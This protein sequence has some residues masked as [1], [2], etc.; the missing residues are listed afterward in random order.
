[1]DYSLLI[2]IITTLCISFFLRKSNNQKNNKKHPP[3]PGPFDFSV[4][5]SLLW[6]V[7]NIELILRDLK[8]KY[9]PLFNLRIGIISRPSIFVASHS[10]AY[11]ALVQ[12]GAV[13]SDRPKAAQTNVIIHSS[14]IN[15]S[16]A[17]YG[18]LWRL[19]RRN[20]TSS[21]LHPSRTKSFSKAR[22]RALS[23][24][25][26]QL[27]YHS[28]SAKENVI[29]HFQYAT[30]YLLVLMCF[31]DKIDETQVKRIKDVQRRWI[32]SVGRFI[33]LSFLPR[34][35]EKIIFRSRWKELI[36]LQ[37]E[38][39]RIFI[40]LI[41]ARKKAKSSNNLNHHEEEEV[42]AYVDTLLNLELPKEKRKINHGEI[43]SLSSEFLTAGTDT[44]STS[45]QWIM[46]NL[47][48]YPSIQEKLYQEISE[49]V[50]HR[51][52]P[53]PKGSVIDQGVVKEED[54]EKMPYLKAVILEGLRR[55]PPGH[56]LQPHMV[57][58][59]VELNGYVIPKDATVNFMIAE[60]GWD[61]YVWE[62]PLDFK[63]DRFLL[64]D[65]S[66]TEEFDITGSREIKMIPFSAGRRICPAYRLAMLHLEYF[67][68]NLIWHF[69]W[70]TADGDNVD[71][72]EK[73]EFTVTM[74]NPLC[75]RIRPRI[76]QL[77]LSANSC[78]VI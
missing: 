27:H 37:L 51:G 7:T 19:L 76:N 13:F 21:I 24:L 63:P 61:P 14:R 26:Q 29:D 56:F 34:W 12:Q 10:L 44:T 71:L 41:E 52:N 11:T 2:I 72:S 4:I 77:E 57:R 69:E 42:M 59:E 74:K 9:G 5:G 30:I 40:P 22:S 39:E 49:V 18:P 8:A 45:L 50:V 46:A 55:H 35:L 47:V 62:D 1:M 43:V 75:A 60:M 68:A 20:L 58:E 33:N 16:S 31:G 25:V 38:Q 65:G 28:D 67:V 23:V 66:D 6:G 32:V 54:L 78:Y 73:L 15:I 64:A 17:P 3:G 53:K 70:T 36:Q 48:K